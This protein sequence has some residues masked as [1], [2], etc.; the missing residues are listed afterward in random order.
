MAIYFSMLD[1]E[2][3]VDYV[4]VYD[5]ERGTLIAALTGSHLPPPIHS[6]SGSL[7]VTMSSDGANT[8][9]GFEASYYT[10]CAA[11]YHPN[12]ALLT[13]CVAC[14]PGKYA[15][16]PGMAA[17]LDCPRYQYAATSGS[18]A[19][20]DCPAGALSQEV[21]ADAV[22][23][24]VCS[25]GYHQPNGSG[26][27]C[28][29]CPYGALCAGFGTNASAKAGY[30]MQTAEAYP[31]CCQPSLCPGGVDAA[32]PTGDG[33]WGAGAV[34]TAGFPECKE[35][36]I[37]TMTV[38]AF[39]SVVVFTVAFGLAC[40]AFGWKRGR[41]WGAATALKNFAEK[42]RV[43][44]VLAG[45]KLGEL[46]SNLVNSTEL[47][48]PEMP[49]RLRSL[50]GHANPDSGRGTDG[51]SERASEA[52]FKT[53][54]PQSIM[55]ELDDAFHAESHVVSASRQQ[56][57][58]VPRVAAP[59]SHSSYSGYSES[60]AGTHAPIPTLPKPASVPRLAI[61]AAQAQ[62]PHREHL[63]ST[64]G[65]SV[66]P[67][68]AVVRA[69]T[70]PRATRSGEMRDDAD[71]VHVPLKS[72]FKYTDSMQASPVG[73]I[74]PSLCRSNLMG[75]VDSERSGSSTAGSLGRR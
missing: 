66:P 34:G 15:P 24:C 71:V 63:P 52:R 28:G 67:T 13:A 48:V 53:G 40:H 27:A 68:D 8:G 36:R 55:L 56:Q 49:P 32:C 26:T 44:D 1:L 54:A 12:T 43:T 30:C 31:P 29:A 70:P 9:L 35:T 4:R 11:G 6:T 37:L 16:D 39:I 45:P 72:P 50:H 60:E 33:E 74:N 61:S 18:T 47:E 21:G 42:L 7:Y 73:S 3:D 25:P 65:T 38:V 64:A 75:S 17:C 62:Q 23:K 51:G 69:P 5:G 20:T 14:A 57:P 2:Q 59:P 58:R 46:T 19:C 22:A 10:E 41:R